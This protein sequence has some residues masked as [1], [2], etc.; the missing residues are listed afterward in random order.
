MVRQ[1]V[2]SL[3]V[4]HCG[5]VSVDFDSSLNACARALS[6]GQD[7]EKNIRTPAMVIDRE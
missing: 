4:S 5:M 2:R 7:Q 1:A 3:I 6:N